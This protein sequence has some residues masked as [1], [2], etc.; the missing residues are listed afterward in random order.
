[1]GK[2][3]RQAL[4][5]ALFCFD[6]G[7]VLQM[8]RDQSYPVRKIIINSR[9]YSKRTVLVLEIAQE[10]RFLKFLKLLRFYK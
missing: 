9:A 3:F 1:M 5:L 6:R 4:S 10:T 2:P 8:F 7:M